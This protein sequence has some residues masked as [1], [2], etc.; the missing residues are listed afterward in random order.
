MIA[1]L[2]KDNLGYAVLLSLDRGKSFGSGF[3]LK[4]KDANYIVTAKHV[5]FDAEEKLRCETLIVTLQSYV[6]PTDEPIILEIDMTK[7]KLLRNSK[8]DVAAI[9]IGKNKKLYKDEKPLKGDTS[10]IKRPALLIAEPYVSNVQM[11]T[12][13]A[14]SVDKEATRGL[15]EIRISNDVYLMGYPTS[16]GLQKGT[17][18]DYTKPLLRKGIIAG[19]NYKE[20]TFIIDCPSYYGNSGGPIIEACEDNYYRV[21][22]LVSTYIPFETEWRNN[23][24]PIVNKE[25][26][27]SGYSVCVPMDAVFDLIDNG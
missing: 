4:Y 8:N 1:P 15:N 11:G 6:S 10:E 17:F 13:R 23:R 9:L 12:G 19:I 5:L 3:R 20:N 25:Y 26:S 22:G 14:V 16:L 24:E 2:P 27:N 7:A 21:V 18:F